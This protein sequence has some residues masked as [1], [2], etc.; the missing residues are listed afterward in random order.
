MNKKK[1]RVELLKERELIPET[2]VSAKS[3]AITN[4]LLGSNF[5]QNAKSIFC[6]ISVK[7]EPDTGKVILDAFS[8]GK[9]VYVPRTRAGRILE[10]VTVDSASYK[11][12]Y[13]DWPL[14]YGIPI[15]PPSFKSENPA[16]LDLVIVPSLAI[17]IFGYRLGYG[18]GYYDSFIAK[19]RHKEKR[20]LF[21]AV[22]FSAFLRN[23]ALPRE[24]HDL[25]V[26]LILTEDAVFTPSF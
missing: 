25:K 11:D 19:Y 17:D 4:L 20:P 12:A 18:G 8:Q 13:G 16:G 3:E 1:L 23:E 24:S 22:Q 21:A 7:G 2:Q 14:E 15:P 6:F 26:D 9:T 5:Y 10:T